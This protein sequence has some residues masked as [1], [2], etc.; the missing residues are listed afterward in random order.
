VVPAI[1]E[2]PVA[3]RP[4]EV[5]PAPALKNPVAE[6]KINEGTKDEKTMGTLVDSSY[7]EAHAS[8]TEQRIVKLFVDKGKALDKKFKDYT[9]QHR[10][11]ITRLENLAKPKEPTQPVPQ[12]D[13]VNRDASV[14]KILLEKNAQLEKKFA[15]TTENFNKR[16]QEIQQHKNREQREKLKRE[17]AERLEKPKPNAGKDQ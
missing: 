15:E 10:K 14:E 7:L 6:K 2:K 12:K 17:K 13:T 5:V 1:A 4:K 8:L 3:G 9:V 16:F 11:E